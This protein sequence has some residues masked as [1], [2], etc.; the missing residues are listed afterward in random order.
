VAQVPD[1][2]YSYYNNYDIFIEVY[3]VFRLLK[4]VES[5]GDFGI[6]VRH[7]WDIYKDAEK[8]LE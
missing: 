1:G 3:Q 8:N 7:C 5:V 6:V 4:F 2:M